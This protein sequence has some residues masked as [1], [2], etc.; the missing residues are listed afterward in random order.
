MSRTV[1]T[2]LAEVFAARRDEPALRCGAEVVTYGELDASSARVAACL[3]R[4][5]MPPGATVGLT[6]ERSPRQV[7]CLVGIVR[8]GCAFC[9]LD[10]KN[11]ESWNRDVVRRA[12]I[13]H[14]LGSAGEL[15]G[16]GAAWIDADE[17]LSAVDASSGEAAAG[18]DD[19]VYVNFS[20]GTT[21]A[22]K[23]IPCTHRGVVGF[24]H[25]P[26]HF[27][28]G[29]G[30]RWVYS[31]PLTFDASQLE[32]WCAL[33]NGGCVV[34]N[35]EP[36]LSAAALRR[37]VGRDGADS[38][39]LTSSLF[40]ALIEVDPG[41][42]DGV[43]TL[44]VGG[45]ALSPKHVAALY[46]ANPSVRAFN[47]YG[48]TEC[49]IITTVYRIPREFPVEQPI[50]IGYGVR[51]SR[52]TVLGTDGLPSDDGEVG[53]LAIAGDGVSPGY[54]GDPAL[55]AEKFPTLEIGGEALRCY[56]SGDLVSRSPAGLF[57]YHGRLDDQVK[58]RGNRVSLS[59][60]AH[61]FSA[62]PGVG[63]CAAVAL[64]GPAGRSITLFYT[65]AEDGP[66]AVALAAYGRQRVPDF[67]VPRDFV[68]LDALPLNGNGKL[69]RPR[70]LAGL[71]AGSAIADGGDRSLAR[72]FRELAGLERWEP[73][74]SFFAAGGDSLGAIKVVAA[75]NRL[76]EGD[77]LDLAEFYR[78]PTLRHL[79][80]L[81]PADALEERREPGPESSNGSRQV[82]LTPPQLS[83]V[84][85]EL[86]HG[87]TSRN[88]VVY[89]FAE[90]VRPAPGVSLTEV[91]AALRRRFPLLAGLVVEDDEGYAFD[92]DA[93]TAASAMVIELPDFESL[94]R[95]AAHAL[96]LPLSLFEGPLLALFRCRVAGR[97][98]H[99]VLLHHVV[100]DH[101]G[102]TEILREIVAIMTGGEPLACG[103]DRAFVAANQRLCRRHL[104]E[105]DACRAFWGARRLVVPDAPV[106]GSGESSPAVLR[107]QIGGARPDRVPS[108]GM[109]TAL[110]AAR[111]GLAAAF[112]V[113]EPVVF[114]LVSL[115]DHPTGLG[116][117]TCLVPLA[118]RGDLFA[119]DEPAPALLDELRAVRDHAALGMEEILVAAGAAG[120]RI[121]FLFNFVEMRVEDHRW[122]SDHLVD[123]PSEWC[124]TDLDLTV[125]R[126][127]RTFDLTVNTRLGRARGELLLE[128]V[129]ARLAVDGD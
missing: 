62:H 27:P 97:L 14:V 48:P 52:L 119:Q 74:A 35:R 95:C 122:W 59:D 118:L 120:R 80:R 37:L 53:E 57:R 32:I 8:A 106:V 23:V 47:G 113:C 50:P 45:E 96:A 55:T 10:R 89:L 128:V 117:Q 85:P 94:E 13:R 12:D 15:Q 112:G 28:A 110:A 70:L 124:K 26:E 38:L 109:L 67:M 34:V 33:L 83:M 49:T 1:V 68:R 3:A 126:A 127:G 63:G 41:C 19:P 121:P 86:L 104:D 66:D 87:D 22:P 54:L 78:T 116:F 46:A 51:G 111:A 17:A 6:V 93:G 20:S 101:V 56:R 71:D 61:A 21:G 125:I 105:Q 31:S 65:C 2:V 108:E 43:E 91:A 103:P 72:Y 25:A 69:D 30:S 107:R 99:G 75:V 18:P 24:C 39:W 4:R 98:R 102:Q 129:A 100:G 73:D 90:H 123:L 60:V 76:L 5:G 77:L 16:T 114:C 81:V 92:L 84:Y 9:F 82:P 79:L 115:R 88:N 40:N 64:E 42:L 7:A 58:V 11:P 36:Y 44:V 29:P